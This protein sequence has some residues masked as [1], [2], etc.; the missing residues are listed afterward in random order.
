M[1][2]HIIDSLRRTHGGC[3]GRRLGQLQRQ[4]AASP[5]MVRF[6]TCRILA[7]FY[8]P[9][10][11]C[12]YSFTAQWSPPTSCWWTRSCELECLLSKVKDQLEKLQLFSYS[13]ELL[14]TYMVPSTC[15]PLLKLWSTSAWPATRCKH[16]SISHSRKCHLSHG[17]CFS[18]ICLRLPLIGLFIQ[19]VKSTDLWH[20]VVFLPLKIFSNP[21]K[22]FRFVL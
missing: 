9:T 19:H 3:R 18:W 20:S 1:L 16:R 4:E 5:F 15:S 12:S 13:Q 7:F 8:S 10:N 6:Y 17:I 21:K 14:V 2:K 22:V 11:Q